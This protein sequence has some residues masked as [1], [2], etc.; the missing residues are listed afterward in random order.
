MKRKY[1]SNIYFQY[2]TR[3]IHYDITKNTNIISKSNIS[4]KFISIHKTYFGFYKVKTIFKTSKKWA[5]KN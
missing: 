5:E 4:L 1:K 2:K 3:I